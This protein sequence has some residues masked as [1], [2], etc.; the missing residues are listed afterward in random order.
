MRAAGGLRTDLGTRGLLATHVAR[1]HRTGRRLLG[2]GGGQPQQ[3]SYVTRATR[4]AGEQQLQGT[5]ACVRKGGEY[6]KVGRWFG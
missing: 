4:L 1:C 6:W 2:L 5:A 3:Q